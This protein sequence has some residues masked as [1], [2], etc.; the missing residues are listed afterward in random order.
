MGASVRVRR[1]GGVEVA[2]C[3]PHDGCDLQRD[4]EDVETRAAGDRPTADRAVPGSRVHPL[5]VHGH[6]G[7]RRDRPVAPVRI[8]L[9]ATICAAIVCCAGAALL[10][11]IDR[12]VVDDGA[13]AA[14]PAVAVT[15]LSGSVDIAFKS[16]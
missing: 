14:R 3:V 5:G 2:H 13:S 6:R 7:A 16:D 11:G 12:V 4:R 10:F 8:A 9:L 15:S 1:A